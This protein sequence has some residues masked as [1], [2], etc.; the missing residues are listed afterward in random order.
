[1]RERITAQGQKGLQSFEL[2]ITNGSET[3]SLALLTSKKASALWIFP[4]RKAETF[5]CFEVKS[6][7][8][9][10]CIVLLESEWVVFKAA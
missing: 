8:N 7:V 9:R 2:K 10:I 3:D 1:M 4:L 5:R 6:S